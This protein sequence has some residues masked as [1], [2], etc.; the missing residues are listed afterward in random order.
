MTARLLVLFLCL[1]KAYDILNIYQQAHYHIKGYLKHYFLNAFYTII[2]PI[3][4]ILVAHFYNAVGYFFLPI[5]IIY[6]YFLFL[7][8]KVKLKFSKRIKLLI[9]VN[10]IIGLIL[11][12]RFYYLFIFYEYLFVGFLYLNIF[13][14]SLINKKYLRLAKKK[15]SKCDKL[16]IGITGSA[17]K[18][19]TKW[20]L[21]NI[22]KEFYDVSTPDN[23]INTPL[24]IASF[25][26]NGGLNAD[27]IVLEYGISKKRDMDKLLA[28]I[29]PD[30]GILTGVLPMHM[31]GFKNKEELFE[32]KIKLLN[33]SKITIA[34]YDYEII[35]N[36][37]SADFSYGTDYGNYSFEILNDN[38][39]TIKAFN[40]LF[41]SNLVGYVQA[42]NIM[43][44][45]CVAK[46]LK[47]DL[48]IVNNI[49]SGI[50]N[51]NHRLKIDGN[52]HI[53]IDDSYNSNIVGFKNALKTLKEQKGAKIL[54]TPGIVELGKY[55]KSIYEE[56]C[57][58]IVYNA[59]YCILVGKH[60]NRFYYLLKKF[61]IRVYLVSSFKEGFKLAK[62]IGRSYE[63][64]AILIENDLPDLYKIGFKI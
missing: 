34:N 19:S 23:S 38:P 24:G 16:V 51:F 11:F 21:Y 3:A 18:T 63:Y 15:A 57:S 7:K 5:V 47:L 54:L 56:L 45:L 22:L 17:G 12:I 48:N 4:L 50:T 52:K 61:A 32:E 44:M 59:D 37:F 60:L 25:I 6:S 14:F 33:A 20:L 53:I 43:V 26:N 30:I 55:K 36:N 58:S 1:G 27:I 2:M 64:S 35:R 28:I 46:Y 8:P 10:L 40:C 13:I 42:Y 49:L 62:S 31:D 41:K 9:P 29:K 39:I